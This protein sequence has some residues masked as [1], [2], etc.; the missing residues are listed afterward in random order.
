MNLTRLSLGIT[1]AAFTGFGVACFLRPRQMLAKIDVQ[2]TS[3]TGV[4]EIR[5]MYGGMELGLGAFFAYCAAQKG[6]ERPALLAQIAGLGG[7]A[8]ARIWSILKDEPGAIMVPLALAEAGTAV[9]GIVA[10][11]R[12]LRTEA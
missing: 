3:S 1:A 7:L 9:L 11:R 10:L 8:A 5:A 12:E 2:P 6:M 4:T